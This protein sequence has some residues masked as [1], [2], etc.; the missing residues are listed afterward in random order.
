[1]PDK[2]V[3]P[4]L[5][6][7]RDDGKHIGLSNVTPGQILFHLVLWLGLAIVAGFCALH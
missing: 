6:Q 5:K 4:E 2:P 7:Q 1:M 3:A